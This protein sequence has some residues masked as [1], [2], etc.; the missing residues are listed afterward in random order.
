MVRQS[1]LTPDDRKRI[2][3]DT[4]GNLSYE[5]ARQS[6]R[7]LGSKFFNELQQT[8]KSGRTK[9]YDVHTIDE[10]E[11]VFA[12]DAWD[13]ME[14]EMDEETVFPTLFDRGDEDAQ[15]CKEFEEQIVLACQDSAELA[16]CFLSYQEARKRLRDKAKV[17]RILAS[18]QRQE[19]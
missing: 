7:L 6:I 3:V 2:V 9:T 5:G 12:M 15:F 16:G 18:W 19:S 1:Q 11:P 13:E 4:G 8:T 10:M 14:P 17:S